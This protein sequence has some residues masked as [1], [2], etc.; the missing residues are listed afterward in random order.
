MRPHHNPGKSQYANYDHV[1]GCRLAP[2]VRAQTRK[3]DRYDAV[4]A[5]KETCNPTV[6]TSGKLF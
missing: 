4:K 3:R 5:E 1:D 2:A 6:K